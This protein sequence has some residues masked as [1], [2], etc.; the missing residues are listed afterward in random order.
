MTIY[1]KNFGRLWPPGSPGYACAH[2]CS[3]FNE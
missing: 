1:S 2:G 3:Y